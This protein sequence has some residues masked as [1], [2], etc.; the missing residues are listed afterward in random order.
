MTYRPL[1]DTHRSLSSRGDVPESLVAA[2]LMLVATTLVLFLV[3]LV[4]AASFA[5]IAQ[6]RLPQFGM[7]AAVGATERQ[8][9][10]TMLADGAVTGATGAVLGVGLGVGSWI[11]F[12]PSM[13][14]A[15]GSRIDRF[16][17]PWLL[18]LV[19]GLLATRD[20]DAGCLVA[21]SVD[22]T[23]ATGRR[24][25]R[26]DPAPSTTRALCGVG[27]RLPGRRR[28]RTSLRQP[29]DR[30]RRDDAR[31]H[32]DPRGHIGHCRRRA[33]DQPAGRAC[34]RPVGTTFARRR[35]DGPA[36][37]RA[38][39]GAFGRS[40]CRD[41]PR[42]RHPHRRGRHRCGCR[43]QHGARQPVVDAVHAPPGRSRRPV[44]RR[45][46][47]HS[48]PASWGRFRCTCPRDRHSAS[49]ERRGGTRQPSR[50]R[51]GATGGVGRPPGRR[52]LAVR[53]QRVRRRR[54]PAGRLRARCQRHP[55]RR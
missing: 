29:G 35:A 7:L 9:R 14:T 33:I 24:A 5:V 3:A 6:R 19:A 31:D 12:A 36:R 54:C 38:P 15:V 30:S 22:V 39:S 43:Q 20:R 4:A 10:L 47:R 50:R 55:T 41:Q 8:V 13:E 2:I 52:W 48:R 23:I 11:G 32:R 34:R 17:V 25:L 53:Q 42:P 49:S 1:G 40:T 16:D 26:P 44:H 21:G 51:A 18:V 27:C 46:G 45:P 37:P 28:C